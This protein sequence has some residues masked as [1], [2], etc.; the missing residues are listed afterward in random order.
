MEAGEVVVDDEESGQ[1]G[2]ADGREVPGRV[3]DLRSH[4]HCYE[5]KRIGL[6]FLVFIR[7]G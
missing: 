5:I 6:G 2:V 7:I 1:A 4:H 3:V